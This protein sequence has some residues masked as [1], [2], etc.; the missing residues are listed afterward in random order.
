M[1]PWVEALRL[2]WNV[3]W[4][5]PPLQ[6][7]RPLNIIKDELWQAAK[8]DSYQGLGLVGGL[9]AETEAEDAEEAEASSAA[10]AET[11][12]EE[13]EEAEASSAVLA[14]GPISQRAEGSNLHVRTQPTSGALIF[15][16]EVA[17]LALGPISQRAEGRNVQRCGVTQDLIAIEEEA[18]VDACCCYCVRTVQMC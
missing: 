9:A 4:R 2:P 17:V 14:L 12:A 1:F 15:T 7:P 5:I 6:R 3:R 13:S 11:K 8:R 10:A 16:E 18:A